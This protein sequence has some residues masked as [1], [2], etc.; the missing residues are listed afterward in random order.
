MTTIIQ[1][2][3]KAEILQVAAELFREKGYAAS[4]MRDIAD[5]V[6]IEAASLYNHINSK[7]EL[8]SEICFEVGNTFV[9][10]MRQIVA[11][12]ESTLSKVEYLI[13]LHIDITTQHASMVSVANDEWRHLKEPKLSEFLEMRGNYEDCFMELINIGVKNQELKKVNATTTLYTILSSVRWLQYWYK[14]DRGI[15][16]DQIK[17]EITGLLLNGIKN[18]G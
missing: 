14:P 16:V 12:K 3:R 9:P 18:N 15:A 1:K 7:E 4:T 17:K 2:T 6:G 11:S 8:L 13:H 5:K 10:E